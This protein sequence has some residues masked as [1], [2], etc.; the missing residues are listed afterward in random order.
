MSFLIEF[1]HTKAKKGPNGE[2][3]KFKGE[4]KDTKNAAAASSSQCHFFNGH[5]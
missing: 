2:S 3:C 1:A 5:S 4:N